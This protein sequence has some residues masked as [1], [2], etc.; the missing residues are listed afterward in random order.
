MRDSAGIRLATVFFVSLGLGGC[1]SAS[2][3]TLQPAPERLVA[4]PAATTSPSSSFGFLDGVGLT[5]TQQAAIK[6]I[7]DRRQSAGSL[8]E[9]RTR[10]ER[11][12]TLMKAAT[13]DTSALADFFRE[14]LTSAER[15]RA[16]LVTD[17]LAVREVLTPAQRT[18]AADAIQSQIDHPAPAPSI[19]PAQMGQGEQGG[20]GQ[21]GEEPPAAQEPL[22]AEQQALF[23]T[24]AVPPTDPRG[25]LKALVT[26]MRS[27]ESAPLAAALKPS[28]GV[29]A[30]VAA[31]VKAYAS[32]TVTQ[33]RA[34]V[35]GG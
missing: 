12:A 13:L 3:P 2:P 35:G 23:A 22:T 16:A 17:Y 28:V 6:A 14:G 10:A 5:A 27:G 9:G 29:D 21:Q 18:A 32:L 4:A 26:L 31:L 19:P 24:T 20:D 1:A 8:S 11:F 25:V 33:R 34:A 7:A 30:Q 15:G